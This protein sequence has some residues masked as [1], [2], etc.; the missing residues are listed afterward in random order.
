MYIVGLTPMT[1]F[2]FFN[3]TLL[4]IVYAFVIGKL[5]YA[6]NRVYFLKIDTENLFQIKI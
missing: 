4:G 6:K 5:Y 3:L 2:K 1:P